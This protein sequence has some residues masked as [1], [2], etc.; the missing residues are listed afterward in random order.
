MLLRLEDTRSYL[1]R[2]PDMQSHLCQG[3]GHEAFQYLQYTAMH[4]DPDLNLYDCVRYMIILWGGTGDCNETR[5][6][7]AYP[8]VAILRSILR[9]EKR[10][11]NPEIIK[12]QINCPHNSKEI[13]L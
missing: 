2:V 4:A 7:E 6:Q 13:G 10:I 9:E 8:L 3:G 12:G 1:P 5:I 11:L